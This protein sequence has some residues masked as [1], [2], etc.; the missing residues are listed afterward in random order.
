M[1]GGT[2]GTRTLAVPG[3]L[4]SRGVFMG[5]YEAEDLVEWWRTQRGSWP[6]S[7]PGDKRRADYAKAICSHRKVPVRGGRKKKKK[8]RP[9]DFN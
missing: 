3:R 1:R 9:L 7:H 4:H 8:N 2:A 6:L 5:D